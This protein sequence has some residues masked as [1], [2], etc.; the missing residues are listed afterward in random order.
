MIDLITSEI[1]AVCILEMMK[2]Q[3]I[4]YAKYTEDKTA[5]DLWI[6]LP[7][8]NGK[9]HYSLSNSPLFISTILGLNCDN[10]SESLNKHMSKNK[11]KKETKIDYIRSTLNLN[12]NQCYFVNNKNVAINFAE[13]PAT[14]TPKGKYF[15]NMNTPWQPPPYLQLH[16][17]F[18][19]QQSIA[20]KA[21]PSV[22]KTSS[23]STT[24]TLATAPL[25][26]SSLLSPSSKS[27]DV[28]SMPPKKVMIKGIFSI[29]QRSKQR[30]QQIFTPSSKSSASNQ[31]PSP[32]C[33]S[34][35]QST[36]FSPTV[37]RLEKEV[38]IGVSSENET[39]TQQQYKSPAPTILF[40]EYECEEGDIQTQPQQQSQIQQ[41]ESRP[42]SQ[43]DRDQQHQQQE[44]QQYVASL[45]NDL[46]IPENIT[47]C[48]DLLCDLHQLYK[49]EGKAMQIKNKNNTTGLLV[50][51]PQ[52]NDEITFKKNTQATNSWFRQILQ[53]V[54][55]NSN[56]ENTTASWFTNLFASSF[57]QQFQNAFDDKVPLTAHQALG[58]LADASLTF[59][60]FYCVFSHL[61]CYWGEIAVL[62]RKEIREI[63]EESYSEPIFGSKTTFIEDDGNDDNNNLREK[64]KNSNNK[65][66]S[67]WSK[68]IGDKAVELVNTIKKKKKKE[69]RTI[70][71]W[72]VD[73][74]KSV[75]KA[76]EKKLK[77]M[78]AASPDKGDFPQLNLSFGYEINDQQEKCVCINIG[79]DHGQGFDR[80]CGQMQMLSPEIRKE[81]NEPNLDAIY[82]DLYH[83]QC[84][85]ETNDEM[86]L[87]SEGINL[88]LKQLNHCKLVGIMDSAKN[89]QTFV[90]PK[91]LDELKIIKNDL[92]QK[93]SLFW[94][95]EGE[96]SSGVFE[97]DHAKLKVMQSPGD[98]EMWDVIPAFD[99]NITGT[100]V[101]CNINMNR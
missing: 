25:S 56:N 54:N 14:E 20:L 75:A 8:G 97:F 52:Y 5:I 22:L 21:S 42:Q 1:D 39:T 23:S 47:F 24:T 84:K 30:I 51:I 57:K 72:E 96:T 58:I 86:I 19:N 27:S 82:L 40:Q 91:L 70:N 60:Q 3:S 45:P 90:V 38:E 16:P 88:F 77:T 64:E 95:A 98:Y 71:Y 66:Q 11:K 74:M 92:E 81:K 99:Y 13:H 2:Q 65:L 68:F 34:L 10:F 32:T 62:Q 36:F 4:D 33:K 80:G 94:R 61:R 73:G 63:T 6:L 76:V 93:F 55:K 83:V 15:K 41:S 9:D 69:K 78:I 46:S 53:F 18:T 31:S 50:Y 26:A 12:Q 35:T 48:S 67:F 7:N 43:P 100:F 28:C 49:K 101:F 85:K 87:V 79:A 89:I 17:M 37:P 44:Q 59:E 29:L